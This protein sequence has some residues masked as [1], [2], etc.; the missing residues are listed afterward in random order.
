MARI[1]KKKKRWLLCIE[2]LN[3]MDDRNVVSEIQW[4]YS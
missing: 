4:V 1:V 3:D 2:D